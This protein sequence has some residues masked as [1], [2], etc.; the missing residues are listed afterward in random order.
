MADELRVEIRRLF[1][2][3]QRETK[4]VHRVDVFQQ[5]RVVVVANT[6]RLPG[7]IEL[8]RER[9]R[10]CVK[11]MVVARLVDAHAPKD[12]RGMVPVP[13]DHAAHVINRQILPGLIADMVPTGNLFQHQKTQ[14]IARV[15]KGRRLWI[16]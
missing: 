14:F 9:V 2:R 1:W 6:T 3:L 8:M 15:E 11:I 5:L 13:A 7:R 16:V 10:A 12:N 4:V